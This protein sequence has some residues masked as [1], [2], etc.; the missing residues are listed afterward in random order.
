[1]PIP[2]TRPCARAG[3][4]CATSTACTWWTRPTARRTASTRAWTTTASCPR[5]SPKSPTT[6]GFLAPHP[7]LLN[8]FF[9]FAAASVAGDVTHPSTSLAGVLDACN[10]NPKRSLADRGAPT[11]C[12]QN[13]LWMAAIVDRGLRMLER[14]KNQPSVIVWSLGNESGYGP[15]GAPLLFPLSSSAPGHSACSR[16]RGGKSLLE[17]ECCAPPSTGELHRCRRVCREPM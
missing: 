3:T 2:I 5:R 16:R 8:S 7:G 13:P 15:G 11:P 17:D 4:S 1:M 6:P 10:L 9:S 12:A 14:D